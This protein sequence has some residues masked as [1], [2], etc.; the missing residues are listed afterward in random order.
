VTRAAFG[1][2]PRQHFATFSGNKIAL[3]GGLNH[4]GCTVSL[5]LPT[6]FTLLAAMLFLTLERVRPGRELPNA[7]EWYGRA[8]L[9]NLCQVGITLATNKLWVGAFSG[10]S[11]VH[12][13]SLRMPVLEGFIGWFV[14]TF[15]FYWWHRIRHMHGF[16]QVFHQV[17]HSP[18]RIEAIT[19]FYKHPV[20]ILVDSALAAAILYL[21]L[22]ASLEGALWFNFFAATGEFFYHSNFKSPPWLK[23]VIQTPELHS[24]HH[25]LDVHKYNFA[26]LPIW[27]RM[28]GTYRDTDAFAPE[29]GFP[30]HNERKL[31]RMLLFRDVYG[32]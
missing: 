21:L 4:R 18:A 30:R 23:Y 19:S 15:F 17:H 25:Q 8:L 16:W 13:A 26:D 6:I 22:G 3:S 5:A 7:P 28:F 31:G 11:V 1:R 9:I 10:A 12:L 2:K 29:C 24:V 14:G 20:E 32:D 27:D